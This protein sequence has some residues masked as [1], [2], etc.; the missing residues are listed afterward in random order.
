M[1]ERIFLEK[2]RNIKSLNKDNKL[3]ISL[4]QKARLLPIEGIS[5]TL[6]LAELFEAER[7][8]CNKYRLIF[9]VNTICSNVLFNMKTEI[10]RNE[11]QPSCISLIGEEC[12]KNSGYTTTLKTALS[13]NISSTINP[14]DHL[15]AI[16]NTEYS[17]AEE[18]GLVYHCGV[19]IFNNH[20][21]RS[22]SFAHVNKVGIAAVDI[23]NSGPV[24]NTIFDFQ[25][26]KD[27]KII[28]E[29]LPNT[30]YTGKVNTHIYRVDGMMGLEEAYGKR[31]IEKDGWF[32][33]N[34]VGYIEIPK[35]N[36][37]VP[38]YHSTS[39]EVLEKGVGHLKGSSLPVGGIGTHAILAAH[40]G[41]PTSKLFSDLDRVV[42][43]DKFY[44][45]VLDEKLV[46]QVD[47]IDIVN[48][49]ELDLLD[50]YP[51]KDYVTLVTCTPYGINTQRLLVRGVRIEESEK[52]IAD[53]LNNRELIY[54]S[55]DDQLL[56]GISIILL[57]I[58]VV[59]FIKILRK[60]K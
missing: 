2:N 9:D 54:L 20:M 18:G 56:I 12:F 22:R 46:Y 45:F 21:L 25:R 58:I 34:N 7:D 51:D 37:K 38:I 17:H 39:E 3:D 60:K 49:D 40:R 1:T 31:L 26:D 28:K 42:I 53:E 52:E 10:V 16:R 41:L 29:E 4:T 5:D 48:P 27:G 13:N 24:F 19:D 30:Q 14:V 33:F 36:I 59:L 57:I 55:R 6:N 43:G 11:G 15:Q 8:N 32:G 23:E 35:I 44:L 50:I 47:S